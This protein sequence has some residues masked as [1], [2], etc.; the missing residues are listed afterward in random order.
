MSIAQEEQRVLPCCLL[1]FWLLVGGAIYFLLLSVTEV[2]PGGQQEAS[3][4]WLKLFWARMPQGSQDR[5]PTDFEWPVSS[6]PQ[7]AWGWWW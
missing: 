3:L 2:Q 4:S 1:Q 5:G 6:C 7:I